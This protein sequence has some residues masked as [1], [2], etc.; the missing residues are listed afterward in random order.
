M[1]RR[2]G[3]KAIGGGGS[4]KTSVPGQKTSIDRAVTQR[5]TPD[6]T[7]PAIVE[8]PLDPG[9]PH[10]RSR[11]IVINEK[12]WASGTTLR[13][14]FFEPGKPGLVENQDGSASWADFSGPLPETEVVRKAFG[15]WKGLGIGINFEEVSDR[16]YA[17]VRIGFVRGDGSWS[18]VGRDVLS[19]TNRD[20]RT[21]NFGW[22]LSGW[23]FGFDTALHEIGHTLGLPHEHQNP[24]TSIIW[25]DQAVLSQIAGL[26]NEWDEETTRSNILRKTP[27]YEVDGSN[28]DL[29]SILNYDFHA[30]LISNSSEYRAK[31]LFPGGEPC[32]R[33]A[34]WIR[35]S[36]PPHSIDDM[37]PL[38][39]HLSQRLKIM[40][41]HQ[42]NFVFKPTQTRTYMFQIFGEA[43]CV[44]VLFEAEGQDAFRYLDGHDNTATSNNAQFS[45]RLHRGRTYVLR[46]ILHSAAQPEDVSAMVW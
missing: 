22:Q 39:P 44:L 2:I 37:R 24:K 3:S 9:V 23:D 33:D 30:D 6:P 41:G 32:A 46:V 27:S 1:V 8:R 25:N 21:M 4:E 19:H 12:R 16:E 5:A 31:Q 42:V 35:S 10:D 38:E 45:Y 20:T 26:P 28:E 34:R 15:A 7:L 43:H 17:E 11:A 29:D 40:P 14:Y 13:Y 18:Y 36:Y